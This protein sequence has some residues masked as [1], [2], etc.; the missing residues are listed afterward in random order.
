MTLDFARQASKRRLAK[1]SPLSGLTDLSNHARSPRGL[2]P[3]QGP[4]R[5]ALFDGEH[6]GKLKYFH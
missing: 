5:P 1:K 4:D 6:D 3:V 2:A